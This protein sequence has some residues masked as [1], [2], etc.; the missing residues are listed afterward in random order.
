MTIANPPILWRRVTFTVVFATLFARNAVAQTL[1][2]QL[3]IETPAAVA[4]SAREAGDAKRGAILFFQP[5]MACA[6][7]HVSDD[8]QRLLGPDLSLLAES[9]KGAED[10]RVTDEQ[11]VEAILSPSKVIRKGF[12]TT[13]VTTT[14]GQ[15]LN[16][17]IA[18][19]RADGVVLRD[20]GQF[21]KLVTIPKSKIEDRVVSTVSLMPAG[22]VNQLSSRQQFLD[23]VRYLIE[24]RDG[25][26]RRALELKP[27]ATLI[28]A[29]P[30]PE[31]EAKVDHAGLIRD[32]NSQSL[33]R[34]EAIYLRVCANCHGTHEMAGTLPTALRFVEG[35][36][37]NGSDP[38]AMY[39][40]LTRGFGFM[41]PQMWMV[42]KQ[43]YDVIH[44]LRET[45]LKSRNASQYV[46]VNDQYLARLPRGDTFGP[47]PSNIEPWV[48]MDYGPRLINS[49]EIPRIA[50][51]LESR[52]SRDLPNIA[53]KGIA[54]RLDAGAGGVSR[55]HEW[56]IFDHDT[57]RQAGVWN[58]SGFIDWN[59]IHFNG[60]HN[61][62]PSIVGNVIVS[63]PVGPGW[64]N[65]QTGSFDDPRLRGRDD[66]PYGPL[67][68]EWAQYRGLYQ[69]AEQTIVSYTVGTTR[70]LE[71]SRAVSREKLVLPTKAETRPA[72]RSRAEDYFVRDFH[73]GPRDKPLTLLVATI[74][75]GELRPIAMAGQPH[76]A[77]FVS[78]PHTATEVAIEPDNLPQPTT[79]AALAFGGARQIVI[80]RPQEFNLSSQDY[81]IV[82]RIR[83]HGD[84]TI[85]SQAAKAGE[86][87]P[88]GKALFVRGGRLTF[89]IGWVGAVMSKKNIADGRWHTVGMTWRHADGDVQLFVD[90]KLDG[91][92]A[93]KP[94]VNPKTLVVRLGYS[95]SNFPKQSFFTGDM[96]WAAFHQRALNDAELTKLAEP[97]ATPLDDALA[98]WSFGE[99]PTVPSTCGNKKNTA[100]NAAN[101]QPVFR[102][103]RGNQHDGHLIEAAAAAPKVDENLPIVV[104]LTRAIVDARWRSDADGRVLLDF[105]AGTEVLRF[106]VWLSRA[107]N[108]ETATAL[109]RDAGTAVSV[110]DLT[111]FT[112][113]AAPRWPERLKTTVARGRDDGPFAVD[114]LTLPTSNPWLTQTRTTGVDFFVDGDRAAVCA[115]DGD[116]WLL[117]GLK[118][119]ALQWQ[120]IA[121]GLFQPLGVKIIDGQIYVTCRDQIVILR[122]LNGDGETDFYECFNNDQQVTEHFHE[123]AMGLQTDA[124]GNLYYAKS[125]RHALPAL[126]P[127]HGTLLRVSKDGS[128]TDILANGF[129]AANGVC[130]NPDGSFIVT[131]QEGHWNPKNRINWV[132]LRPD[133]KPNFY[134]NMFGYHDVTDSSD[135]AMVPPLCWIT[136]AFDRSPAELLWVT[137]DQWGPLKGSLLNL[138]YGAGKVF[139]VPHEDVP[140][141]NAT[142][143]GGMCELPLPTFPT[144]V[145]RGRFHPQ[146]GQLYLCGMF[147][148]AG[149]VTQPGG[150]Y[151]I[152]ATGQPMHVPLE[153]HCRRD[154]VTITLTDPFDPQS[155]SKLEN[156]AIQ[157]W[158]LKRTANYGSKHFDERRLNVTAARLDPDG[159][160]IH[161]TIPELQPTWG[162]EIKMSL[163]DTAGRPIV[164]TIH[165]TIH[166]L[167]D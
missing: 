74:A 9:V 155:V 84:G 126:V 140:G 22:Q 31:Y 153:L 124:D 54:V 160:T 41:V 40:T 73:I 36:F 93:L 92:G 150:L 97:N 165:N 46:A 158:S 29:L 7:C 53:Y 49:Y 18:E 12:E 24:I 47:E 80:D 1:E 60:R 106:S 115:W 103:L 67:P 23:L 52:S 135:S 57:L 163:R 25:G 117:S 95:A 4:Q 33:K 48:V 141:G 98:A 86:W 13:T 6:K 37:K 79:G 127:H 146:D 123:F 96:S 136:N 91:R 154:T 99:A 19:D 151:R 162:M 17:L 20:A 38:L 42:P 76:A 112:H 10:R 62:H 134:G 161:L 85:F 119:D 142:K 43:K 122:D 130:L 148:W 51:S 75:G 120:R 5:H 167:A 45:Y 147:A 8:P 108:V 90:G 166:E 50:S 35:K 2:Q 59:G 100:K 27:D 125:A 55:G 77:V 83:T 152:R 131:D 105:P 109:A 104:G 164:R 129:R 39:Q 82:A 159:K 101:S 157:T 118:G 133:G 44:Y 114:V 89:D 107:A 65:P 16:G 144:G 21:G 32:W 128:R 34:G 15:T 61:I 111:Q 87:I 30:L 78:S 113:G 11:L 149:N 70:V 14:D 139:V 26:P 138:S 137:S 71:S 110:P 145:M 116:I 58:G 28:A 81:S 121:S 94:K 3:A 132:T 66:R 64:A 63:N 69:H 88:D 156:F 68:R 72:P 56:S 143:Q 102:D